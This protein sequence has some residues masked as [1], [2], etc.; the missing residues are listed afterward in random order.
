MLSLYV[1]LIQEIQVH[2]YQSVVQ[3]RVYIGEKITNIVLQVKKKV[4]I[5]SQFNIVYV[6]FELVF[7]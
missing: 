2:E 3:S 1:F 7:L 6:A 4:P 5:T